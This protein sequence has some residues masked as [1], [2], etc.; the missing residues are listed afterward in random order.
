MVAAVLLG[1]WS[2][3]IRLGYCVLYVAPAL[4]TEGGTICSLPHIFYVFWNYVYW[5]SSIQEIK[6]ICW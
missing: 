3:A 2:G 6:H 5:Q 1:Q 4:E